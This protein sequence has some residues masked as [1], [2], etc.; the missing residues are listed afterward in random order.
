MVLIMMLTHLKWHLK[1][2][3]ALAFKKGME[4]AQPILLEPIMK[5]NYNCS[6]GIYG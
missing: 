5:L 1:L 2:A 6:R 3:A 4:E